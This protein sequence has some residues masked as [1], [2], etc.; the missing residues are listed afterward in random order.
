MSD[1]EEKKLGCDWGFEKRIRGWNKE[2]QWKKR[3][4]I[5]RLKKGQS[6]Y[7]PGFVYTCPLY[8]YMPTHI[9]RN[10]CTRK[11]VY[12][13][14]VHRWVHTFVHIDRYRAMYRRL[15]VEH[16]VIRIARADEKARGLEGVR[17]HQGRV[18]F[19]PFLIDSSLLPYS[20]DSPCVNMCG[21]G[22]R[23]RWPPPCQAYPPQGLGNRTQSTLSS[24]RLRYMSQRSWFTKGLEAMVLGPLARINRALFIVEQRYNTVPFRF[25]WMAN[26]PKKFTFAKRDRDRKVTKKLAAEKSML[27]VHW[28]ARAESTARIGGI[29]DQGV[30]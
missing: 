16:T 13:G 20:I 23:E 10:V 29:R 25:H 19:P 27:D 11:I 7:R 21:H 28:V 5:L 2:E 26:H 1:E 24:L 30:A 3:R 8:V 15:G 9:Y 17:L 12:A 22:P 4:E 6:V 18:S 14:Y